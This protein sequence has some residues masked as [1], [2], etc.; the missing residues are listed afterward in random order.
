MIKKYPKLIKAFLQHL[1][2]YSTVEMVKQIKSQYKYENVKV[3][4]NLETEKIYVQ[5]IID[6]ISGMTDKYAISIFEELLTY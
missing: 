1:D 6:F 4:G 2:Q 5:S 3:Y